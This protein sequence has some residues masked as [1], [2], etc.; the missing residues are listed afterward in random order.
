MANH[1]KP[2]QEELEANA[3]KALE[4]A[5]AMEKK[6]KKDPEPPE[7]DDTPTPDPDDTP[8]YSED[9]D[10]PDDSDDDDDGDDDT[11]PVKKHKEPDP[12]VEDDDL[13]EELKKRDKK[14]KAS[15]RE[16]QILYARNKQVQG[17]IQKASEMADP[18]DEEMQAEYEDW[19]VMS[20][21]EKK[22]AK[23]SEA[24]K[25]RL[26]A[27]TDVNQQFKDLEAWTS[28]VDSFMDNPETLIN[29]PALEGKVEEFKA[30]ATKP[31]RRGVDMGILISSFLYQAESSVPK[32][33][34][35]GMFP[36]G[37]GGEGKKPAP[38][39]TKI[40]LE[41]SRELRK[42][43]YPEYKR[44]MLAGKL[45]DGSDLQFSGCS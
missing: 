38:K 2:T 31:T 43:N 15:S 4:E 41:Q 34:K 39:T 40:S 42:N 14:L 24:S 5:E 7:D 6:S 11:P 12:V 8:D 27:I 33:K 18:T 1:V 21:F 32:K 17:A 9:D 37:S 10:V 26:K 28:E 22:M 36:K 35:K 29:N 20:D 23:E 3:M 13:K 30:F 19:D 16:A 25:R 44:L 45:D